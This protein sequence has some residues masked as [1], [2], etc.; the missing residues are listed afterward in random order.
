MFMQ[1]HLTETM[2]TEAT[3]FISTT[4]NCIEKDFEI[5]T[6]TLHMMADPAEA[7][8]STKNVVLQIK[9]TW[10]SCPMHNNNAITE[11]FSMNVIPKA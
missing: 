8:H 11:H 2:W 10:V 1:K 6:S 5:L 7:S 4:N 3:S 9:K